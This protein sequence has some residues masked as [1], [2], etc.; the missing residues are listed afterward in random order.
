MLLGEAA[1]G[2]GTFRGRR[3]TCHPPPPAAASWGGVGAAP[4]EALQPGWG[5]GTTTP[6]KEETPVKSAQP[7]ETHPP[8][9]PNRAPSREGG[10]LYY[11]VIKGKVEMTDRYLSSR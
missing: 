5:S 3:S 8:L 11:L 1:A 2:L 4:Q 7:R 9:L 6:D 10:A